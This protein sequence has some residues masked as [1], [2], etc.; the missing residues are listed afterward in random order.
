MTIDHT[1]TDAAERKAAAKA[2]FNAAVKKLG[3]ASI[4][5]TV[6]LAGIPGTVA[7]F[8]M[9]EAASTGA[10]LA[11]AAAVGVAT[12]ASFIIGGGLAAYPVGVLLGLVL[13]NG[14]KE[15]IAHNAIV[16]NKLDLSKGFDIAMGKAVL[17]TTIKAGFIIGAWPSAI[18]G[19]HLAEKLA[20]R[21]VS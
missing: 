6:M 18:A 8:N 2:K 10:G 5:P 16:N 4:M 13:P 17:G 12:F 15:A 21:L 19:Y 7:F 9:P 3:K 14:V 11:G 1:V 20:H